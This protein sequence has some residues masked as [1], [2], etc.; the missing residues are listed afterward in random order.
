M[1][2]LAMALL[3]AMFLL[4]ACSNP[5]GSSGSG[6]DETWIEGAWPRL[7]GTWLDD[8]EYAGDSYAIDTRARTIEY[9]CP[10]DF[11]GFSGS[12]RGITLFDASA[13]GFAGIIVVRFITS[14]LDYDGYTGVLFSSRMGG[15]PLPAGQLMLA[16]AW[17]EV[18]TYMKETLEEARLAFTVDTVADYFGML[19]GPYLQQ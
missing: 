9:N 8:T 2:A 18:G 4:I 5:A 13:S 11:S 7:D 19:G 15:S 12:I 16:A 1:K 14:Q 3:L 10:W 17:N 6:S